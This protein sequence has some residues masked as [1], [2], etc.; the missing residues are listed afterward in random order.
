MQSA[1]Q[2]DFPVPKFYGQWLFKYGRPHFLLQK[3]TLN[4]SKFIVCS[5]LTWMGGGKRDWASAH[6]FWTRGGQ[7]FIILCRRPLWMV[8]EQ[9]T[10]KFSMGY[11]FTNCNS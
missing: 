9:K 2:G 7:F 10:A 5:H 8:P 3:P 4:F 1:G 11:R 6:I